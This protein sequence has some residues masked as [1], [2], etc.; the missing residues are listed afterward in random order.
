[1]IELYVFDF[2]PE[3]IGKHIFIDGNPIESIIYKADI[4]FLRA[5]N[6]YKVLKDKTINLKRLKYVMELFDHPINIEEIKKH[7]TIK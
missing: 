6:S 5:F 1:M 2:I 7:Y 3:W 4:D